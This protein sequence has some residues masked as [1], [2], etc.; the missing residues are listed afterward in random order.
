MSVNNSSI[1]AIARI[2]PML[3]QEAG[4]DIALT[5]DDSCKL[6]SLCNWKKSGG[7]LTKTYK[8]KHALN[9]VSQQ[10]VFTKVLP[11]I[12]GAI[13]GVNTSI[14]AYGQTGTGKTKSMLGYDITERSGGMSLD[15]PGSPA[16]GLIPRAMEWLFEKKSSEAASRSC[17][18]SFSVT[19]LEIYNECVRDLLDEEA[20]T[21]KA[22]DPMRT[23]VDPT[24]LGAK[25]IKVS[26]MVEVM[27][28]LWTG[29]KARSMS[30]TDMNQYSSRSH[31]IFTVFIHRHVP[32]ENS[33]SVVKLA[34]VDL[35]GSEKV[36]KYAEQSMA[37][38]QLL[39]LKSINKSLGTLTQV[40]SGL[41]DQRKV[42]IPYRDSKLTRCLQDT[43]GNDSKTLFL[44][45]LSPSQLAVEES[46]STLS[47]AERALRI[48]IA[49][50]DEVLR[51][52]TELEK[53]QAELKALKESVHSVKSGESKEGEKLI[54]VLADIKVLGTQ[55]SGRWESLSKVVGDFRATNEE[56]NSGEKGQL[57]AKGLELEQRI[58]F[59]EGLYESQSLLE[60]NTLSEVMKRLDDF[61]PRKSPS[62]N[63]L[64]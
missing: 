41:L 18:Y 17:V 43:L 20:S 64:L 19:Y 34:F 49:S 44:C 53:T 47:F 63:D 58:G 48:Q 62:E 15:P 26:N 21:P 16:T 30:A 61:T 51:L 27:E 31:T 52:S 25:E 23:A 56:A 38:T 33:K 35:A 28:L 10:E 22:L 60:R 8:M 11:M 32:G 37:E 29:A 54:S 40:I 9:D 59:V 45:T 3:D 4:S 2:R 13:N 42:Y 14:I 46:A 55:H 50:N 24:V 7:R 57:N 6:V 1:S 39:E 12:E 5:V 36:D